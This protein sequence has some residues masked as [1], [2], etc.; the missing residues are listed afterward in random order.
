MFFCT[1]LLKKVKTPNPF[2][3]AFRKLVN[4]EYDH[5]CIILDEILV[6]HITFP[7]MKITKIEKTVNENYRPLVLRPNISESEKI[8]FCNYLKEFVGRHYDIIE[9]SR[10]ILS[11]S[12]ILTKTKYSNLSEAISKNNK[13][14][15]TETIFQALLQNTH[16]FQ[17]ALEKSYPDLDL[18]KKGY[19]TADDFLVFF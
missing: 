12:N 18:N 1:L 8:N 19:L 10:I 7:M 17:K 11:A 2:F 15:C 5:I 3:A 4:L 13:M 16:N 14:V 6:F 9:L